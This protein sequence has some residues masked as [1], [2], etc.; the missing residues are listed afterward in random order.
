M[1][2]TL[3]RATERATEQRTTEQGWRAWA[4][5]AC[6]VLGPAGQ[7]VQFLVTPLR[8]GEDPA[9]QVAAAAAHP[10]ATTLAQWLDLPILLVIPAVLAAGRL[11][12]RSRTAAIG[13]LLAFGTALGAG[14]LL[15][16]DV[17]IGIAAGQP[18]RAAAAD[19]VQ[20][21]MDH[22]VVLTVVVTYL[23]GHLI[24]FVLLGIGLARSKAVGVWAG[25]AL[26]AWPVAEMGGAAAGLD[27]VSV[28]GFALLLAG[29]GA[30]A[31]A[32][33]RPSIA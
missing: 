9:A 30:C 3:D 29:F 15:A 16:G 7:L 6:L 13:T 24:G 12:G 4:W 2:R 19:W 11:A 23:V 17:E 21:F 27:V 8:Q 25:V 33:L 18:D 1:G 22:P 28:A 31:A 5:A 10:G 32:T 26:A 20:R 14:Y